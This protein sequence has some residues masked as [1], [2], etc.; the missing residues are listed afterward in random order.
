VPQFTLVTTDGEFL[1][2]MEF[3][4]P[5]WPPGSVIY[6]GPKS[7]T[8]VVDVMEIRR[9]SQQAQGATVRVRMAVDLLVTTEADRHPATADSAQLGAA[10]ASSP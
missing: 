4:R 2:A 9:R 5:D 10:K 1:G 7:R 6:T 3:A 8:C